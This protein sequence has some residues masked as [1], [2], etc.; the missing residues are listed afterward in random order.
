MSAMDEGDRESQRT[1]EAAGEP[2]DQ[3]RAASLQRALGLA[4][5]A[6]LIL[7]FVF[8]RRRWSSL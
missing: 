2:E 8:L 7:L 5:I 1:C 3:S 4:L 6:L